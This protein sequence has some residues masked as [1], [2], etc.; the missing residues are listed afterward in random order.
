MSDQP[1]L[2]DSLLE[3][4]QSGQLTVDLDGDTFDAIDRAFEE[5]IRELTTAKSEV[6]RETRQSG[7]GLGEAA[8][9]LATAR[10]TIGHLETK[11]AG[12]PNSADAMLD[13]Y[14]HVAERVQAIF[15]AIRQTYDSTEAGISASIV[16][17]EHPR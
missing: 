2:W 17:A 3:Q 1:R 15:R 12:G 4:A 13:E 8:A 16:D 14:C 5:F 7:Y 9:L 11:T 10:A 6:L